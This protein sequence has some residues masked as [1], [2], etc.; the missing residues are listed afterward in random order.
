[1]CVLRVSGANFDPDGFLASSSLEVDAVY[2]PLRPESGIREE[3]GMNV[4]VSDED[5]DASL[6]ETSL[7]GDTDR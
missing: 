7:L 4:G 1:M 5:W 6:F 3:S 2:R